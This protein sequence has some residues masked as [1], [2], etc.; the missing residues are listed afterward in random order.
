MRHCAERVSDASPANVAG[1]RH[2]GSTHLR[3]NAELASPALLHAMPRAG[4][5]LDV[6]HGAPGG[7]VQVAS[8]DAI[9]GDTDHAGQL[10]CQSHE[11]YCCT[12]YG[13]THPSHGSTI[14]LK[15]LCQRRQ[16][17]A[18]EGPESCRL[19]REQG[20]RLPQDWRTALIRFTADAIRLARSN[21]KGLWTDPE[22]R[23]SGL[24]QVRRPAP[25]S[26]RRRCLDTR[27]R[28]RRKPLAQSRKQ[29]RLFGYQRTPVKLTYRRRK[30][31]GVFEQ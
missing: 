4:C 18:F 26:I 15:G 5:R 27:R 3:L 21:S 16:S 13:N 30:K 1:W 10:G 20:H 9:A 31:S 28:T 14:T 19:H 29:D 11:I 17:S 23:P 22:A 12:A 7:T 24:L 8:R 25:A 6:D 2:L